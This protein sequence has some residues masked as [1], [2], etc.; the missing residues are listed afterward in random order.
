M[1]RASYS[2]FGDRSHTSGLQVGGTRGRNTN[3]PNNSLKAGWSSLWE[4]GRAHRRAAIIATGALRPLRGS[5]RCGLNASIAARKIP[6]FWNSITATRSRS[7]SPLSAAFVIAAAARAFLPRL[8]SAMCFART[9]TAEKST[10]CAL[11]KIEVEGSN[12]SP[13]PIPKQQRSLTPLLVAGRAWLPF[14]VGPR[15]IFSPSRANGA[16]GGGH[17]VRGDRRRLLNFFAARQPGS[18]TRRESA[19]RDPVRWLRRLPHVEHDG[20]PDVPN[21]RNLFTFAGKEDERRC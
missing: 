9:A 5:A 13:V 6:S 2:N 10:V 8:Q 17:C 21:P 3:L 20:A 12:P 11:H 16:F 18:N 15:A 7:A 4:L 19:Y 1:M 14:P